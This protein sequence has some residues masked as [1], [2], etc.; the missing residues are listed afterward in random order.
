MNALFALIALMCWLLVIFTGAG[1]LLDF[2]SR[3]GTVRGNLG[4]IA[5]LLVTVGAATQAMQA[6]SIQSPW[7]LALPVGLAIACILRAPGPW[8]RWLS[9]GET[10]QR[11]GIDRRAAR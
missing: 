9:S 8:W 3:C 7:G 5:A 2:D 11:R 6:V 1:V 4:W 10:Y